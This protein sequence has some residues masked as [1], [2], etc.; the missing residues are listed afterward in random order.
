MPFTSETARAAQAKSA[1]TRGIRKDAISH[2]LY[3]SV[4]ELGGFPAYFAKLYKISPAKHADLIAKYIPSEIEQRV[5]G[6]VQHVLQ[7]NMP[8]PR[9][10]P[11]KRQAIDIPCEVV[12]SSDN[13]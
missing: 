7:V 2:G 10:L 3:A 13:E 6:E 1:S 4:M 8:Q 12:D 9:Q 5:S 11:Q